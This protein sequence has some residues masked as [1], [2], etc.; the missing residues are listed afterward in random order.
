MAITINIQT[1]RVVPQENNEALTLVILKYAVPTNVAR[2]VPVKIDAYDLDKLVEEFTAPSGDDVLLEAQELY[3]LEYILSSGVSVLAYPVL[4]AGT[5]DATDVAKVSDI[6]VLLY[7]FVVAP[8]SYIA[9]GALED[10]LT[11]LIATSGEAGIGI[12][13]QLFLDLDPDTVASAIPVITNK[14]PKI[15]LCINGGFVGITSR[16]SSTLNV[17]SESVNFEGIPSSLAILVRKA[18]LL[19]NGK[20]WVPVAGEVNGRVPEFTSL[21]RELTTAEK[22]LFQ[23]GNI[24]VLVSKVGIGPLFV[25]QNT[26]YSGTGSLLKSHAVTESLVIK[27]FLKTVAEATYFLPNN[28]RTWD[29]VSLK[30]R[31]LLQSI[32]DSG[33][34]EV[35]AIAVGKGITMTAQDVIDGILKVAVSYLPVSVIENIVFNV[36]IQETTNSYDVAIDGGVL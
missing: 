33:G 13:A 20:S 9:S 5:F 19:I 21:Y 1:Q 8:F 4:V 11:A 25:S 30:L 31:T 16:F 35:Y 17:S 14:S 2:G 29:Q 24:N 34:I 18:S 22:V 6:D 27:R 15:E 28:Q 23:A 32:Q 10:P 26:Q 36:T 7:K 12:D 3:A